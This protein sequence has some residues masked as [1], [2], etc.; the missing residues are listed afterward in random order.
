MKSRN[1]FLSEEKNLSKEKVFL[2]IALVLLHAFDALFS[3]VFMGVD[4]SYE[5]NPIMAF[6]FMNFGATGIW[7]V[8]IA[9]FSA[10]ALV[11]PYA[12]AWIM[13]VLNAIMVP[14]VFFGY[15]F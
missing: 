1:S 15:L 10:L 11:L 8:K 9:V 4:I 6:V 7:V 2:F 12:R 3:N 5:A 13:W 14:V